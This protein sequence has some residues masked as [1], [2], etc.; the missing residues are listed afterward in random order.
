MAFALPLGLTIFIILQFELVTR[1]QPNVIVDIL[2]HEERLPPLR[3]TPTPPDPN[4]FLGLTLLVTLIVVS[5]ESN[6][7]LEYLPIL[8]GIAVAQQHRL[9]CFLRQ[10]HSQIFDAGER[11]FLPKLFKPVYLLGLDL[12][13]PTEL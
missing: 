10:G 11:L 12:A 13:R 6:Q 4:I 2:E 5:F 1:N 9:L 8:L 3:E 7:R